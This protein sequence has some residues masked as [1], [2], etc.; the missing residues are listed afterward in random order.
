MR[1]PENEAIHAITCHP[2][3]SMTNAVKNSSSRSTTS[4]PVLGVLRRFLYEQLIENYGAEG[5]FERDQI[6]PQQKNLIIPGFFSVPDLGQG[7]EPVTVLAACDLAS[8]VCCVVLLGDL[9]SDSL[10]VGRLPVLG[11]SQL[12]KERNTCERSWLIMRRRVYR[13]R[14]NSTRIIIESGVCTLVIQFFGHIQRMRLKG[15]TR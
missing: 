7:L 6:V 15:D 2:I 13:R 1:M 11:V 9:L 10:G 14:S 12:R 5:T 4:L 3:Q 8:A